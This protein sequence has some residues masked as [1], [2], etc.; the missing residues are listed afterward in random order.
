MDCWQRFEKPKYRHLRHRGPKN[1]SGAPW[2]RKNDNLSMRKILVKA[3][4]MARGRVR[5]RRTAYGIRR[6][7]PPRQNAVRMSNELSL[8]SVTHFRL[9]NE[10][11]GKQ[12]KLPHRKVQNQK[13]RLR[14]E[15]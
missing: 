8:R 15:K 1:N 4:G 14:K 2:V 5:L 12:I 9:R 10:I 11:I 6:T 3:S 13:V 7:A